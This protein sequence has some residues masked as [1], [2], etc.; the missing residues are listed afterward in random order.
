MEIEWYLDY[1][2]KPILSKDKGEKI[3]LIVEKEEIFEKLKKFADKNRILLMCSNNIPSLES[4]TI[5]EKLAKKKKVFYLGD[6]RAVS[7]YNYLCFVF[8]ELILYSDLKVKNDISYLGLKAKHI[9]E[10]L[11]SRTGEVIRGQELDVLDFLSKMKNAVNILKD[12]IDFLKKY[13]K[14]F[15]IEGFCLQNNLEDYVKKELNS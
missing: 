12:D 13:D 3:V 7:L 4:I 14:F 11:M 8:G 10:R 1:V 9:D 5:V 2:K 6:L 15:E